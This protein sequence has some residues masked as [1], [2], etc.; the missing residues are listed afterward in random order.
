M[1]AGETGG[2]RLNRKHAVIIFSV[3]L[4]LRLLYLAEISGNPRFTLPENDPLLYFNQ[5]VKFAE[6]GT[7]FHGVF[8]KAP[9]YPFLLGLLFKFT[10]PSYL[11][12]R[13]LQAL[14]GAS[15]SVLAAGIC[16]K[17]FGSRAGIIAGLLAALYGPSI[18]FD[19]EL[20][21]TPLITVLDLAGLY[22]FSSAWQNESKRSL[23]LAAAGAMFGFS[24][25]ARPTILPFAAI[26]FLFLL[27]KGK[28]IKGM[29]RS[30]VFPTVMFLVIL[31]V[32]VRNY[33]AGDDLVLISAQG[34]LAFYTGNNPGSDGMFGVPAGF[35]Q[36]GGNFEYYDCVKLAEKSSG[37]SLKPSEVSDFFYMEG[38]KYWR[39]N[40]LQSMRLLIKKV[41]L[42]FGN[43]EISN[44]QD[45]SAWTRDSIVLRILPFNFAFLLG[46]AFL[47]MYSA[48]LMKKSLV[49]AIPLCLFIL[50]YSTTVVLFFVAARYRIP[51]AIVL[52]IF[53]GNGIS[54]LDMMLREKGIRRISPVLLSA[55]IIFCVSSA[56]LFGL[57][58]KTGI[59]AEFGYGVT[60]LR[61][62]NLE[63][64]EERFTNVLEAHQGYPRAHLNLGVIAFEKAGKN[65][66]P[67]EK[68]RYLEEAVIHYRKELA[69]NPSDELAFN[70]L[71][72]IM[73][74]RGR[75]DDAASFFREA[76]ERRE[77]YMR[78]YRNLALSLINQGKLEDAADV[79]ERGL[80][81][82]ETTVEYEQDEVGL[83][84]DLGAI[85]R[86]MGL[87]D[88]AL[89]QF[90][91]ARDLNRANAENYMDI[92]MIAAAK[93][94]WDAAEK[95]LAKAVELDPSSP[96]G[97]INRGNLLSGMGRLIEALECYEKAASLGS[98][99]ALYNM[100]LAL[101]KAG[102]DERAGKALERCLTVNPDHRPAA[103]L[104][105]KIRVRGGT[106]E[107]QR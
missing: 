102:M 17:T 36:I 82:L 87:F 101:L 50:I 103:G 29:I 24:A 92:G 26:I 80:K 60:Y 9:L 56:D 52:T 38:I 33:R 34:G 32:T 100:A 16:N 91:G 77:N 54:S 46:A 81:V 96:G 64:A 37:R 94:D 90:E 6:T 27:L 76:L 13:L 42:F 40:P 88:N 67:H 43:H 11:I 97:W 23:H 74:D 99:D 21:I 20:L 66:D 105:E 44:N 84:R 68:N 25:L 3:A 72:V 69:L 71:G 65:S 73:L 49:S 12:P 85:Y 106:L 53:A 7:L 98:P 19:G 5:A 83:R 14:A 86:D 107:N 63:E 39:E 45:I 79:L 35:K 95:S 93:G 75:F 70:N 10:G 28:S 15:S 47:G 48:L 57:E 8:F 22:Y 51:V 58:N 4:V 31:P 59:Q 78:A 41:M 89:V 30:M 18:Y 55:V 1:G 61:G 2:D 104:I 62:G